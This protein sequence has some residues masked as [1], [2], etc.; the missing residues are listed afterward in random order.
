MRALWR[1]RHAVGLPASQLCARVLLLSLLTM[2]GAPAAGAAILDD[3]ALQ[4]EKRIQCPVCQGESIAFSQ[5]ILAVQMR[6]LVRRKLA[7][8]E[9]DARIEAYFVA[10]YGEGVLFSPPRH[11]VTLVAWWLP[12]IA[13]A[14]AFILT[15][16]ALRSWTG[17]RPPRASGVVHAPGGVPM[18]EAPRPE[19][20]SSL[21]PFD[22]YEQLV[23]EEINRLAPRLSTR[24]APPVDP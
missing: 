12:F 2:G 9:T 11:G 4:I 16:G 15:I 10:R 5:A 7:Q 19:D 6:A 3:H 13:V 24:R 8:G 1:R 18:T 14:A 23:D 21:A 17:Q 20:D 22:V